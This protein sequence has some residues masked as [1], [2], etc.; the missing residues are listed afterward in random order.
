MIPVKDLC[1]ECTVLVGSGPSLLPHPDLEPAPAVPNAYRCQ[2][3][4]CAWR[5][6]LDAGWRRQPVS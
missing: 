2:T 6:T 3:C 1:N 5:V 4:D